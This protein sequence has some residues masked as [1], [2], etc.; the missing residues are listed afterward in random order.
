VLLFTFIDRVVLWNVV[1]TEQNKLLEEEMSKTTF[2]IFSFSAV[3]FS[4]LLI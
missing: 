1:L 3:L 4:S 2:V